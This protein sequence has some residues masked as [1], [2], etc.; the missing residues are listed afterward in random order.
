MVILLRF[1]LLLLL[2]AFAAPAMALDPIQSGVAREA[3]KCISWAPGR[4]D[5]FT[6]SPA[7]S[8]TWIYLQNEQWSAPKDLGGKLA[9]P[10]S[11]VARGPGGIN[12]FAPS[13]KG[14]LAT[15]NLNGKTWSAWS[16]LGGDLAPSRP[17]CLALARDRLACYARGRRG[18]LLVRRWGGG[19]AWDPWQDLGGALASDPECIAVGGAGI[20][21]FGRSPSGELIGFLPD[22]SGKKGAWAQLGGRISGTPS[23]ARLKSGEAAC[24][25]QSRS[26]RLYLWRGMP[27]DK[28]EEPG[29]VVQNDEATAD[30]PTCIMQAGAFV[31]FLRGPGRELVRRSLIGET[32]TATDGELDLPQAI[33]L[34]CLTLNSDGVIGCGLTG[35]DRK[36]YFASAEALEAGG[37]SEP[38]TGAAY[39]EAEGAWFLSNVDT[40]ASCRVMLT[41]RE[42][43]GGKRLQMGPRC[44][45]VGIAERPVQWDQDEE[46]LLFLARDGEIVLRFNPA[47]AGRWMT[48][49]K[50]AALMLSRDPPGAGNEPPVSA[51][52]PGPADTRLSEMF[53]PWRVVNDTAGYLCTM[54][55]TNRRAATGYEISWDPACE[56]RFPAVRYWTESAGAIVFV[57]PSDIVVARFDANGP[58]KWRLQGHAGITLIR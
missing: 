7:G 21:C 6:R 32:E 19:K 18:Q 38:E 24:A 58:G 10:P 28:S 57:G 56:S 8:L 20:A 49:R 9:A 45:A 30:D 3:P 51:M 39:E 31:C 12:C 26:G 1:A 29:R 52:I 13:T 16:S 48:P 25:A 17:A 34:S 4:V 11:C 14:V 40:G 22:A 35:D 36:L 42:A 46:G 37:A 44:R 5:C 2:L 55:L 50:G 33:G 41:G 23:C 43:F 54:Q 27:L 53:G 15:I 47:H